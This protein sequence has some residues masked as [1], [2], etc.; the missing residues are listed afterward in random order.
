MHSPYDF[1]HDPA[2][3]PALFNITAMQWPDFIAYSA[4]RAEL[5]SVP[6]AQMVLVGHE[7]VEVR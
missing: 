5:E 2:A 7:A 1:Y 3:F 4:R 6:N